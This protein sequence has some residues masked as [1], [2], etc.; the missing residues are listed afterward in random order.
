MKE[1]LFVQFVIFVL[2][3]LYIQQSNKVIADQYIYNY[4]GNWDN[5]TGEIIQISQKYVL[6]TNVTYFLG[7]T[8][9]KAFTEVGRKKM[10]RR[11]NK[12]NKKKNAMDSF[13][14]PLHSFNLL[15]SL[16]P[17]LSVLHT[18]EHNMKLEVEMFVVAVQS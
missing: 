10:R 1:I 6:H 11:K 13:L 7:E 15:T 9:M 5:F 4:E 8:G 18:L 12:K 16:F 17:F 14:S 2:F 3:F